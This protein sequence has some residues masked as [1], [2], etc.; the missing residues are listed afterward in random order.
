MNGAAGVYNLRLAGIVVLFLIVALGQTSNGKAQSNSKIAPSSAVQPSPVPAASIAQ[1]TPNL[2]QINTDLDALDG[3]I[4]EVKR[5]L[6]NETELQRRQAAEVNLET[7][8]DT[9]GGQ[10]QEILNALP[11]LAE[12]QDLDSE[13]RGLKLQINAS[14]KRLLDRASLLNS[15][16]VMLDLQNRKWSEVL[17]QI[18]SDPSLSELQTRVRSVLADIATTS[19]QLRTQLKTTISLETRLSQREQ[20]IESI[21]GQVDAEKTQIQR[22]LFQPDSLPLWEPDARN[23]AEPAL[24]RVLRRHLSRDG[25]RLREFFQANQGVFVL[26][27]VLFLLS[28]AVTVKMR[29]NLG[30]WIE[31]KIVDKRSID[32]IKRPYSVAYLM[33]LLTLFPLLP[34]A[35][36][37]ARGI[38]A[39]LFIFLI[40]RLI[41]P[42]VTANERKLIYILITALLVIQACRIISF[43]ASLK[44]HLLALIS[45]LIIGG[46]VVFSRT[47]LKETQKRSFSRSVVVIGIR[48]CIVFI[49]LSLLA[50]VF[51]YFALSQ[52]MSDVALLGAYYALL[53]YAA[54]SVLKAV[55]LTL[56]RTQTASRSVVILQ[57]GNEIS[58]WIL[59]ILRLVA[60]SFWVISLLRLFT[61]RDDVQNA[62]SRALSVPLSRSGIGFT[63]GDSVAITVGHAY[64]GIRYRQPLIERCHPYHAVVTP[65]F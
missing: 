47:L 60:I 63:G 4:F 1:P 34:I 24:Q 42:L 18:Q 49:F 40:I 15:D 62:I 19:N 41:G 54:Y 7:E 38:M 45:I 17:T 28:L 30:S 12:L 27:L 46:A 35:P 16:V 20:F 51:G 8:L 9:R 33:G 59:W 48:V 50:N 65:M 3:Q 43:S 53:L 44:R 57:H 26:A 31:Q 2:T 23:Q 39:G 37:S 5:H 25:I 22:G 61:I 58:L 56:L 36:S 55:D 21:Q 52:V 32:L 13:W 14:Q 29:Q 11:S 10:A 6:L 64:F